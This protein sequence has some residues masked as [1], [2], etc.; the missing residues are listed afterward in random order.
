MFLEEFYFYVC[1]CVCFPACHM[2]ATAQRRELNP[3]ELKPLAIV[4]HLIRAWE[5]NVVLF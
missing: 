4:R 1:I 5:P 3:L 2:C